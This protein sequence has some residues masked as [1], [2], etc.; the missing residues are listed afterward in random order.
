M[1][2]FRDFIRIS[3]ELYEQTYSRNRIFRA[4]EYKERYIY[5]QLL[6]V[7]IYDT[8]YRN[9]ERLK[10]V[11]FWLMGIQI[12]KSKS[13]WLGKDEFFSI[14]YAGEE[15]DFD[16]KQ[17]KKRFDIKYDSLPVSE[18]TPKEV[19]ERLDNI[20]DRLCKELASKTFES[21]RVYPE[22]RD[23]F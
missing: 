15:E 9:E 5:N 2:T 18:L 17:E 14:L 4:V 19:K 7:L 1:R 12:R 6:K 16:Y 8:F 3:D 20:Y 11:D 10:D 21:V 22:L 23:R 13:S